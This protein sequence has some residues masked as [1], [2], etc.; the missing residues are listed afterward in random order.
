MSNDKVRI[1]ADL[2]ETVTSIPLPVAAQKLFLALVCMQEKTPQRWVREG[3][4]A[5]AATQV[6]CRLDDLRALGCAPK[7]GN[8]RFFKHAVGALQGR[9]DLFR[10]IA[11]STEAPGYLVWSFSPSIWEAMSQ[12]EPYGLMDVGDIARISGRLD[13]MLLTRIVVQRNK[14]KPTVV[15]TGAELGL[16][17]ADAAHP[18]I[19]ALRDLRRRLEPALQKWARHTGSPFVVGYEQRAHVP[20]HVRASIR[21]PGPKSVWTPDTIA[22]FPI[23][24]DVVAITP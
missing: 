10:R 4:N 16:R 8:S 5:R 1:T 19:F 18:E 17:A 13:L 9:P 15:L 11:L 2:A 22:T 7:A 14:F 3:W 20:G 23:N 12:M 21:F 6:F 24:T